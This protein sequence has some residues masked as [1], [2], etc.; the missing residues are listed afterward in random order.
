MVTREEIRDL[1]EETREHDWIYK[2]VG[3]PRTLD[4][5]LD[6]VARKLGVSHN[7][8]VCYILDRSYREHPEWLEG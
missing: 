1:I 8:L 6:R 7:E 3:L 5:E 4:G 2:D